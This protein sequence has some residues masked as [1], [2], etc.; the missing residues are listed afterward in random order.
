MLVWLKGSDVISRRFACIVLGE[1][2]PAATSTVPALTEALQDEDKPV[3]ANAA[4]ALKNIE[5]KA[6][7]EVRRVER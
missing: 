3:R 4:A 6:P 5:P 1:L 2:G 7:P